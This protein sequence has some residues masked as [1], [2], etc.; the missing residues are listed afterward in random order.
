MP[1][2]RRWLTPPSPADWAEALCYRPL[3]V[4][5]VKRFHGISWDADDLIDE[6]LIAVARCVQ[7]YRVERGKAFAAYASRAIRTEVRRAITRGYRVA[8]V[9]ANVNS[10]ALRAIYKGFNLETVGR[11]KQRLARHAIEVI[12]AAV[13]TDKRAVENIED[14]PPTFPQRELAALAVACSQLESEERRVIQALYGIDGGRCPVRELEVEMGRK[15]SE[16]A[17]IRRRAIARL[18]GTMECMA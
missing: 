16:I 2:H 10:L 9:P 17:R 12:Q 6:G 11:G 3:V 7:L 14:R 5:I 13:I 8:A 1:A 15:R 4:S 18:A